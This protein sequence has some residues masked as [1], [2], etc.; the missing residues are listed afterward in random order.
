M[1]GGEHA[2]KLAGERM[3]PH[4]LRKRFSGLSCI[5]GGALLIVS[6]ASCTNR[7]RA[8]STAASPAQSIAGTWQGAF[9]GGNKRRVVIKI[10]RAGDGVYKA[11]YYNIDGNPV[12]HPATSVTLQGST[13]KILVPDV[14]SSYEGVLSADGESMTGSWA[15]L[16]PVPRPLVLI[17]A[18]AGTEWPIS[19]P[20]KQSAQMPPMDPKA[21]PSYEVAT[22]KPNN[23]NKSDYGIGI[24][25]RRYESTNITLKDLIS[26]SFGLHDKQ[27][28][29]LPAWANTEKYDLNVES[30]G[31]G[32]PNIE[33]WNGIIKKLLADRFGLTFH[34]DKKELSAYILSVGKN[35]PML[36]PSVGV[37]QGPSFNLRGPGNLRV[38]N[39]NM[40]DITWVMGTT[41]IGTDKL[42]RPVVDQTGLS[43]KYDFVL[44][45]TPS[46][47]RHGDRDVSTLGKADRFPDLFGAVQEQLGLKLSGGR[48]AVDVLVVDRVER[49]S[50][51]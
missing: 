6:G 39:A 21:T 1:V 12:P 25:G 3:I 36:S 46:E 23:S 22:I 50:G 44:R 8:Q 16:G 2:G 43:G 33:Q 26:A 48:T 37:S 13:V 35:G 10:T 20:P 47:L 29:G 40:A 34:H 7:A 49:P 14:Y 41:W 24:V 45:W 19:E 28:A 27:V 32:A 31:E 42:D 17:R 30:D 11:D 38:R 4:V 15:Q 18:A 51:N 5:A 9:P